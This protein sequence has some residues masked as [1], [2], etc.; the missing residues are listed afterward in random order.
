[1][2]QEL[3]D[4]L[5]PDAKK[6]FLKYAIK[7]S[8]KKTKSKVHDDFLSFVKHVW[9]EFIEGKHHK[10]IA[11]KF[12]KLANGEIKRLIINMPPRHTKSEFASYL[13]P[14]WMVG[15]RPNLK[16]IQTTHTTELAIRFGRKAKL[17]IDSPEYQQVFKTRLREDSQAAGKWETEQGGEYYAAGV[18]SAI[19]GRG[20]DLLIID[21]PHSEQDAINLTA[22]ERAYEWYT[23]GPRQRLQP[24]GSI[25]V[26]MT[27]WN[28][29]DLT[30]KL[31]NAQSKLKADQWDVVEFPAILE[32]KPIWP[33]YWKLE[34]LESVQASLSVAKWNAQWQQNP[35]SEEGSI[36]KR[37]WWKIWEKRELP[38]INHIIQSYD[39]AFS[40]KETA[41]YS[42]ITTWGVFLYNDITPN[43]IL[44]DMK[45][46]RWDFPDL[47]R[48]A[49]EEYNYWEP[50]TI[51]IEQKASG[52]PL[53]HELRRVGIPVVNFTPSKGN[54]K[55][56]RVNS[57]SPLFEAGQVWAPK[58][59]W[60]EELIEECAAFPYGDH[61]DLVDSMTQAL[62][63]YRQV[64]LAVH[65][66]DYEDPPML[67]QLPSQ[68]DYY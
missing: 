1:M 55:H 56:V 60:A 28:M 49:M 24:G 5:P 44:L 45:K 31:L 35:T 62:M 42:A 18:G 50:E 43:V 2:K 59:K 26:V 17:L 68:R 7:L 65:P 15:R 10:K 29:K 39:T 64:G 12:N 19:T 52:T 61:D 63:R 13:L 6:Q 9:P 20:A 27:R 14:S 16:I 23:S 53:T 54:D 40:K 25:V 46:G 32:N 4:K 41:D 66:E 8:E 38:K 57:V 22:L 36:I 21:D 37:E 3:I 33:Q 34:E 48:I 47:K 58:E 11:D 67:Q 51:I 30:G